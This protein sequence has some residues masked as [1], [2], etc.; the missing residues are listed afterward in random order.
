MSAAPTDPTEAVMLE[1][2]EKMP[3]PMMR[4]MLNILL[5]V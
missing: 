2:V 1:G 5:A 4:P 3:V